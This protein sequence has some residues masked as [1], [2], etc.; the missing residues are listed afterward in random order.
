MEPEESS[1]KSILGYFSKDPTT[2]SQLGSI[3]SYLN[4]S[5]ADALLVTKEY[6]SMITIARQDPLYWKQAVE[7]FF[8]ISLHHLDKYKINWK[9]IYLLI[10]EKEFEDFTDARIYAATYNDVEMMLVLLD[11]YRKH[12]KQQFLEMTTRTLAHASIKRSWDIVNL[13]LDDGRVDPTTPPKIGS[14]K[15]IKASSNMVLLKAIGAG[16]INIV[17]RLLKDPRVIKITDYNV[18]FIIAVKSGYPEVVKLLLQHDKVDPGAH[19]DAAIIAACGTRHMRHMSRKRI[20]ES[21]EVI[22]ETKYVEDKKMQ[23]NQ[24]EI[25][26]LLLNDERV[27]PSNQ[28]DKALIEAVQVRSWRI[29]KRLLQDDRVNPAARN[30]QAI[31]DSVNIEESLIFDILLNDPRVDPSD[32]NNR[33]FIIASSIGN[34]H[35]VIILLN[36]PRVN[37][38]DRDNEAIIAAAYNGHTGIIKLLLQDPRVDPS[39]QDNEALVNAME[40][41]H[42]KTLYVLLNDPRVDPSFDGNYLLIIAIER[43]KFPIHIDNPLNDE[44]IAYTNQ[45][46]INDYNE[47]MNLINFLLDDPRT[48]PS[49]SSEEGKVL[50]TAIRHKNI[51]VIKR[52]LQDSRIDPTIENNKAIREA[53]DTKQYNIVRLLFNDERVNRSL[54]NDKEFK[55]K[56]RAV[57]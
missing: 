19:R 40:F 29:V 21:G 56:I 6:S 47:N 20:T 18:I 27:D 13:L 49:L 17:K 41:N 11:A 10:N 57:L 31:Y 1:N 44:A 48:D 53:F 14:S 43:A 39:D 38:S 32:Q 42:Y 51:I 12:D 3:L 2:I 50:M 55:Q 36:D 33:T 54:N 45:K 22:R 7:Q 23:E 46:S 34:L 30:N 37:P 5:Q 4:K 9:R 35:D 24:L 52:L 25:V 8:G 16:E 26:N 15:K 28:S